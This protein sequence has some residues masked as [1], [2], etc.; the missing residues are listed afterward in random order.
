MN[1]TYA[2]KILLAADQQRH[3]FL[4]IRGRQADH[5]VRRMVKAGLLDATLSDGEDDSF[6]AINR[7]TDFGR[8]LVRTLKDL[9]IPAPALLSPRKRTAGKRQSDSQAAVLEKWR[10]NFALGLPPFQA[11]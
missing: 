4:R 7:L 9:P 1:L 5:E 6:T 3:G 10:V 8:K 11:S 2:H